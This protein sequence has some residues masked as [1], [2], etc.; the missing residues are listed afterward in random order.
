MGSGTTITSLEVSLT[1]LTAGEETGGASIDSYHLEWDQ[2]SLN[3][4]TL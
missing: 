2:G 1:E 4:Q 3:W